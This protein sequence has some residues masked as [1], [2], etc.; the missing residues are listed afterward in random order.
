MQISERQPHSGRS[1]MPA[2]VYPSVRSQGTA[3]IATLRVLVLCGV[4]AAKR[5]AHCADPATSQ[6]MVECA[7]EHIRAKR[8]FE[9]LYAAGKL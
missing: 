1:G 8:R 2:I 9:E 5:P 6:V 4:V 3:D 7:N